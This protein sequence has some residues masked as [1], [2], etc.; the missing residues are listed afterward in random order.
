L[1]TEL[2]DQSEEGTVLTRDLRDHL[3]MIARYADA[4]LFIGKS[5]GQSDTNEKSSS[6]DFIGIFL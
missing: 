5:L 4:K 6:S 2:G 3:L 1:K